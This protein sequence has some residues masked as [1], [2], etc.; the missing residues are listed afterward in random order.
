MVVV[1]DGHSHPE[2]LPQEIIE[3][4]KFFEG[5]KKTVTVNIYER[6]PNARRKCIESWGIACTACGLNFGS[7]YGE[8]GE[9]FIHVHHLKPL[10]EIN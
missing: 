2:I 7:A 3:P 10:A 5:A 4:E 8:V 1:A 6:D 9:G